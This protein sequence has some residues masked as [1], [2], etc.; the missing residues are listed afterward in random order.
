[1]LTHARNPANVRAAQV[2]G[3]S[4]GFTV[5]SIFLAGAALSS[6]ILVNATRADLADHDGISGEVV[7]V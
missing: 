6:L 4:V 3:Y 2:H 1:L 5:G 7:P